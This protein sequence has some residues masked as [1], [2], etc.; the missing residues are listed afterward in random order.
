MNFP[1]VSE[2]HEQE[3]VCLCNGMYP[4]TKKLFPFSLLVNGLRKKE[5]VSNI[6][7]QH[8]RQYETKHYAGRCHDVTAE[9]HVDDDNDSSR[10]YWGPPLALY[11]HWL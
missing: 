2:Q 7:S 4:A 1:F 10:C 8:E 6:V 5:I 3:A 9:L 11:K